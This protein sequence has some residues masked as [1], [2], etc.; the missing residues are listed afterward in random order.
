M[1]PASIAPVATVP[2]TVEPSSVNRVSVAA[3]A[4]PPVLATVAVNVTFWPCLRLVVRRDE[5]RDLEV[6]LREAR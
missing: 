4:L 5:A 2:T 1:A 3:A 6:G